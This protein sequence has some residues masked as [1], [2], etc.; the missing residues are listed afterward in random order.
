MRLFA[1]RARAPGDDPPAPMPLLVVCRM[2]MIQGNASDAPA[3]AA[4]PIFP[5]KKPSKVITPTNARKL[6]IFG[7]ATRSSVERIGP[8][9]SNLV[10]AAARR[11]GG[12]TGAAGANVVGEM[13][14]L[15]SLIGAPPR[16]GL[17]QRLRR[18][19]FKNRAAAGRPGHFKVEA[20][21]TYLRI[22]A[23]CNASFLGHA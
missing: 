3:S 14:M 19:V 16:A 1:P 20:G 2:S 5:R 15:W 21:G 10:R 22:T 12:I 11:S 6:R 7:A 4:V 13:L 8:S 17:E 9:S 23:S 18:T